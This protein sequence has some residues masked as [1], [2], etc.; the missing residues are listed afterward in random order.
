MIRLIFRAICLSGLAATLSLAESWSG[1][2]VD[3]KCYGA[4]R[5]N[6]NPFETHPASTDLNQAIRYCSPNIKTKF[7][8]V[9]QQDGMS[10]TLDSGGNAKAHELL[11]ES[12]KKSRYRVTVTGEMTQEI[13]KVDT[14]TLGK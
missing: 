11:L 10:F 1:S 8:S 2:L 3:S 13:L 6:V 5:S 7:F 14:I 4:R 9:V 12:G